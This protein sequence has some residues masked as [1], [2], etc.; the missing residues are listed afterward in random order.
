MRGRRT[1]LSVEHEL[2]RGA[3]GVRGARAL[4]RDCGRTLGAHHRAA[5]RARSR[6]AAAAEAVRDA[7]PYALTRTLVNAYPIASVHVPVT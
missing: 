1:L 2:Q 7:R 5:L 6:R 4:R 3:R